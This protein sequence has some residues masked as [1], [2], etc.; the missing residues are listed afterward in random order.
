MSRILSG[1]QPSGKLHLGNLIGALNN[2][3]SL[4]YKYESFFEIADLHAL[5]TGYLDISKLK[6]NTFELAVDIISSGID[7]KKSTIFVQSEIPEHCELHLL[8]SMI[9][10]L[11]W[12]ERVPTYKG[13]IDELKEIDLGTYGFLGYPVLQAADILIYKADVVPVG[14][15][16]LP[17]LELTREIARRF[18]NIYKPVF[19]IPKE[20][21]AKYPIMPGIDG[22]KMSK[23]YGNV[24]AISD[25][26]DEIRKKVCSMITDPSR[27]RKNDIG[28]P[29]I[30]A[31]FAYQKIYNLEG[32][33]GIEDNC[34]KGSIG[35]VECKNILA[36][37]LINSLKDIH[38]KRKELEDNPNIVKKILEE[39]RGKASA[40]ARK[41]LSEVKEAMG[42]AD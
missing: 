38:I 6:K 26:I 36:D 1:I 17:H 8:L 31:V 7:P 22:R 3:K 18:N 25:P 12:L 20:V 28:H 42:L 30:C 35:C 24:I 11:S 15:D 10:P 27:I 2:W 34:K 37:L 41:T 40:I 39:G 32:A 23:S 9:T 33:K 16:Q 14:L 13:K 19:P 4:Q 29:D 21:L 5:T